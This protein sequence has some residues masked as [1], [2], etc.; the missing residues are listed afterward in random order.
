MLVGATEADAE[1]FNSK[2]QYD[3]EIF[4]NLDQILQGW[5]VLV[6]VI[7]GAEKRD[8]FNRIELAM[9]AVGKKFT[10]LP[11]ARSR[12]A[13]SATPTTVQDIAPAVSENE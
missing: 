1:N 6:Y 8:D 2:S 3:Y 5:N 7:P 9:K 12:N 4:T 11:V 13:P 10:E